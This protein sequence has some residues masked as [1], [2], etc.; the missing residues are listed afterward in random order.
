MD[1]K[2]VINAIA[3]IFIAGAI[4]QVINN[5]Q[6]ANAV[7]QAV[8]KGT[9]GYEHALSGQQS[10]T[11]PQALPQV[12][13][14]SP[15]VIKRIIGYGVAVT[16]LLAIGATSFWPWAYAIEGVVI[17]GELLNKNGATAITTVSNF[18]SRSIG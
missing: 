1:G 9:L 3:L 10:A 17:I 12:Q 16:I 18:V 7:L 13:V 4:Y 6:G 14:V 11:M 8:G 5:P 15:D 2:V